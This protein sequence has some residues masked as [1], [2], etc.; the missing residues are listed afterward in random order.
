MHI[1]LELPCLRHLAKYAYEYHLNEVLDAIKT[2][3]KLE[4]FTI[5]ASRHIGSICYDFETV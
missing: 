5:K 3:F 2:V 4:F 1:I